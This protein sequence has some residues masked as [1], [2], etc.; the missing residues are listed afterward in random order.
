MSLLGFGQPLTGVFQMCYLVEDIEASMRRWVEQL[1]DGP[2]FLLEHFT[3]ERGTYRGEPG[4]VDVALAMA[5]AGH[6]LV[7]LIAPHDDRPSVYQEAIERGGYG[8]HHFGVGTLDYDAD[9]RPGGLRRHDGRAPRLRRAD[10]D[11]RGDRRRLHALLRPVA[12]LGR[13]RSG[14]PVRL[15]AQAAHTRIDG[16]AISARNPSRRTSAS[17]GAR[18]TTHSG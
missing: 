14:P 3:G 7:E 11:G 1:N 4:D 8:F 10:R 2:W 12:G 17:S 13:D 16:T 5:H 9:R 15:S 6:M 18:P